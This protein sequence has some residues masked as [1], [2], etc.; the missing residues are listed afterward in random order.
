MRFTGIYNTRF[1]SINKNHLNKTI[2]SKIFDFETY[3]LHVYERVPDTQ[4]GS[5]T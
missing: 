1:F 4:I 2:N 3:T 5:L